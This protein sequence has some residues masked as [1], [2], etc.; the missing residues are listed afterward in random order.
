LMVP[1]GM[2]VGAV[3][4]IAWRLA[5]GRTGECLVQDPAKW[6]VR[7]TDLSRPGIGQ[8]YRSGQLDDPLN[9][10]VYNVTETLESHT[11]KLP[12]RC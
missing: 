4:T 11:Y 10:A 8:A 9:T 3:L 6:D 2:R 1:Q 12:W 5:P 7:L